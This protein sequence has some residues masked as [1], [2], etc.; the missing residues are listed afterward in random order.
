MK[1]KYGPLDLATI[2]NLKK[3]A[4][5]TMICG[6]SIGPVRL[7]CPCKAHNIINVHIM[8]YVDIYTLHVRYHVLTD[9][10][11]KEVLRPNKSHINCRPC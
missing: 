4:P 5:P 10:T 2:V 9:M 1:E 3:G 6:D 8:V 7:I 11:T